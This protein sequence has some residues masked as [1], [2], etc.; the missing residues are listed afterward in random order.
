MSG[1]CRRLI[2]A[3]VLLDDVR[4]NGTAF[5][6][7]VLVFTAATGILQPLMT[8]IAFKHVE[9]LRGGSALVTT[10]LGLIIT[11]VVVRRPVDLGATTWVLANAHRV[12]R[13]RLA[14][15]LF[16]GDPPAQGGRRAQ[17]SNDPHLP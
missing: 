7:A 16:A 6:I 8:Q 9:A 1:E 14:G 15:V 12:A 10:L 4:L 2:V 13:T 11:D 17:R 5:V 3:A